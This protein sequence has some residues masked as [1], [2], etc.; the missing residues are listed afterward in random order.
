MVNSNESAINYTKQQA[1]AVPKARMREVIEEPAQKKSSDPVLHQN[2]DAAG[3]AGVKIA[4]AEA[5]AAAR[6][7]LE[8]IAEEGASPE[9]S[10][11][12]KERASKLQEL[13]QAK[14]KESQ[15]GTSEPSM[16]V[17]GGY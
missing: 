9:A 11:E 15:M 10:P 2:L 7:L 4:S 8:K 5:G 17:G 13:L 3:K 6:V 14:Q 12:Q 16:P 1:K